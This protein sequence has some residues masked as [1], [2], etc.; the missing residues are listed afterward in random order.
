MLPSD[1]IWIGQ[2]LNGD[3]SALKMM[4]PYVIDTSVIYNITG[5]PGQKT[6]L[7]TLSQMFLGEVIQD[8]G[9]DG[10]DPKEDAIAAMWVSMTTVE[11]IHSDTPRGV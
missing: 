5:I 11:M 10:H 8:K 7:K 1:A 9:A 2:S 3:L 6:K 4:H